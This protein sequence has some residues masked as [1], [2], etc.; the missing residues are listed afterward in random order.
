MVKVYLRRKIAPRIANGHPW[1]FA[2]EVEKVEGEPAGGETV[3]V[4]TH[5]RKYVGMGY[6][7]PKSQ[8]LVRLLT[9]EKN[10]E[11]NEQ[12]FLDRIRQCWEYR[13][14]IGYVENCRLV[15]GE[16]D[17]LPQLIIDKFNDYFVIQTLTLGMDTWKPAIVKAL[18]TIFSPKG[19]YERNDVPVRELEGLTQHKGFLS[20]PF[21]TKIII[22]E[23]GL[24]FHVDIENGQKTG[25][26][27]DQQD[28][29]RAIRH[30][31]KDADVLGAFTYTGTFE[32]HAASY[33]AKSVLGLD[34]SENAVEQANRNAALNGLEKICRFEAAN[35][36]DVL[37]QWGKEGK[38]YDVVMLD[39][40]A[41]TKSRETIQKAITGYKEINLRGMKLVKPGGF[42]VTSSCTNLVHPELFLQ[43]I[44]M[45]AK[46]ARR[47]IR[48]VTF[49]AQASDHPIIWGMD[50]TNYLKFLIVQVL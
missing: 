49:Q 1:I 41:F 8:I 11:I 20:A 47:S 28:N 48:Q 35:A 7:N 31:V 24:R 33:G 46:D 42:L 10:V 21:D 27:L 6:I 19:I 15:F 23:N 43:T 37:K 39:P 34:I 2:N 4:F 12:F 36:F 45:A 38:Q 17:G 26:F 30:I 44:Q 50:N 40:P 29:R 5:D 25:Y 22:N 32:I 14:R 16:A 18:E 9:R 13:Q 3:T